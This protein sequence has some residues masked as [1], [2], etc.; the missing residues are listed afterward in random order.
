MTTLHWILLAIWYHF[1][2][3]FMLQND[4]MAINK[5]KDNIIL[6]MHATICSMPA[7]LLSFKLA[8][9]LFVSHFAI[10]YC[11]SRLNAWLWGKGL[12]HWFFTSIGF[13]QALHMSVL[14][15]ALYY[16][17]FIK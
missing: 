15:S 10:D 8:I 4:H 16:L 7:V 17:G 2:T 6:L 5:S 3:D 13:D 14:M 11:S 12:R 9:I 1:V